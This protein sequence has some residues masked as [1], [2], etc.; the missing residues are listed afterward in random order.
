[1]AP[2]IRPPGRY[3]GRPGWYGDGWTR[4]PLPSARL[5]PAVW[6]GDAGGLPR[7]GSK[8]WWAWP[9]LSAARSPAGR[10]V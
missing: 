4:C 7:S 6:K 1:V 2:T 5:P 3:S 8:S 10:T 9:R